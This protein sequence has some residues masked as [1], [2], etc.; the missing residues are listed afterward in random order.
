MAPAPFYPWRNSP[1]LQRLSQCCSPW[2]CR[3]CYL[4]AVHLQ[5]C[6]GHLNPPSWAPHPAPSLVL[7][8]WDSPRQDVQQWGSHGPPAP[9]P[10][11]GSG[12]GTGGRGRFG[13]VAP[14]AQMFPHQSQ[15]GH[16]LPGLGTGS[17]PW[18]R[19]GRCWG[20]TD[21]S[22][23]PSCP[24]QLGALQPCKQPHGPAAAAGHPAQHRSCSRQQ[25][26]QGQSQPGGWG[27]RTAAWEAAGGS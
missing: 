13:C 23:D 15:P 7:Q 25:P 17:K 14:L 5:G 3:G 21:P 2:W 24:F 27:S 11:T 9:C 4:A 6:P 18:G 12:A 10:H 20:S 8:G 16:P 19:G 1:S 26:G 22:T